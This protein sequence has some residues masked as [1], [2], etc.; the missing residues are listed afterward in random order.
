MNVP[1]RLNAHAI[2]PAA[3]TARPTMITAVGTG[4]SPRSDSSAVRI[5]RH[6][7]ASVACTYAISVMPFLSVVPDQIR[8]MKG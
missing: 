3:R 4:L 2:T 7:D 6:R 1:A 8:V 5:S